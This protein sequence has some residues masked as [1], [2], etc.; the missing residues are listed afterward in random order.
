ML[1]DK[2]LTT[3]KTNELQEVLSD[4]LIME[5]SAYDKQGK[6]HTFSIMADIEKQIVKL[7]TGSYIY[8]EKFQNIEDLIYVFEKEKMDW[9]F[10]W[11]EEKIKEYF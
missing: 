8:I 3:S 2:A 4:M 6:H 11:A 9:W 1:D 10:E 7:Y 5:S